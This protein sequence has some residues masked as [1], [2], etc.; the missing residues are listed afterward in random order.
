[1]KVQSLLP[2]LIKVEDGRWVFAISIAIAGDDKEMQV[3]WGKLTR[4]RNDSSSST[5]DRL[6][7]IGGN[8]NGYYV[9]FQGEWRL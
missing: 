2:A 4:E 8:Q 3:G 6:I 7:S 1:M 9:K 5:S